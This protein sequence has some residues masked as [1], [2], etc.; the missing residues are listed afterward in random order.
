LQR[1]SR[2]PVCGYRDEKT[3]A[4]EPP[5]LAGL[6]L[7]AQGQVEPARQAAQFLADM[8]NQDG[9]VGVRP[10]E[11]SPLWPT[12]LAL[13]L[14]RAC[15]DAETWQQHAAAA[16]TWTLK[17]Q[18]RTIDKAPELGHNTRLVG[19]SW[20]EQTHSWMEPTILH[21]LSLKAWDQSQHPR[22]REAITLLIDRQLP[23]GGCNY[24]NT[25]VLGQL[26]RPHL[27]PS[28]MLLL[29]LAD[30]DDPS[31]RREK[32]IAYVERT[33]TADAATA[34]LCWA[35]VG[36]AAVGKRPAA[37]DD[38]LARAYRRVV[39]H[40]AAPLSLALLA[41]AQLAER[42]PLVTLPIAHKDAP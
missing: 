5:A 16:I 38:W 26:L 32:S 20:A 11:P 17:A 40:G 12:S 7:H 3:P 41:H 18:G 29:A 2:Q 21:V 42:S 34:S 19:W 23:D 15:S 36:L 27:M 25:T 30:E 10:G 35:L 8:Q 33:V 9:S 24:G 1:L 4:A 39:E 22:T 14:W 31:G 13:L 37:A 6:A 28:G